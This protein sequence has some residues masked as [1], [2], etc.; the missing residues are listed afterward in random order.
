MPQIPGRG[1]ICGESWPDN[2]F[3]RKILDGI[4]RSRVSSDTQEEVI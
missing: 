3:G 4:G 1:N 2:F